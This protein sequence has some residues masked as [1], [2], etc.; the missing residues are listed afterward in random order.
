MR[1]T[2]DIALWRLLLGALACLL[3]VGPSRGFAQRGYPRIET[4][5]PGA[6]TR[7]TTTEVLLQGRYNLKEA[8]RIVF[9]GEGVS[10]SVVDWSE[11]EIT[12]PA[13][14]K[15]PEFPTETLR[16]KVTVAEDA[17]PGIRPFRILT[18]GS[19]SALAHLFVTEAPSVN[20]S[21]PND[22]AVD[23]QT[24]EIPQTVNGLLD[25]EVDFDV[26]KFDAEA[27]ERVSFIVH[28]A[29]L[30]H[31]V[32]HLERNFADLI[33]SLRDSDDNEF[34]VADDWNGQDP[35]LFHTFEQSGT[36]YLQ[37]REARY[38]SGKDKWWYAL[39]VRTTPHVTSIFP[40][41]AKAGSRAKLE[42]KGFNL[43]G[44]GPYEVDVPA[45]ADKEFRFQ[46]ATAQGKSDPVS[47]LM[48][49]LLTATEPAGQRE[50][51]EISIPAGISGRISSE[52]E[53]DRYRFT[54]RKGDALEFDVR[55]G[56]AFLDPLLEIR[57][58]SGTLLA[59][60]DDGVNTL[61]QG[62]RGELAFPADKN[63]RIEWIAPADGQYE[64]QVRDANYFGGADY[65]YHL[66][67]RPQVPDFALIVDDD[68]MP[69]GPGESYTSVVTIERRNGFDGPVELF[70]RGLPAGVLFEKSVIPSHLKQGNVVLTGALDA[71]PDARNVEVYGVASVR[72]AGGR[73]KTIERTAMPF[74]PMGQAGGRSFY[75]VPSLMAAAV[76][77]SD[78]IMEATP[79]EITLRPGESATVDIKVTRNNFDGPIEMNV[80]LW[81]L[82]QSLSALPAGI[83]F[84]EKK[85]KTSLGPGET[86]GR[87]TFR[88]E[89]DA[90]PLDDYL[91]TVLGQ[92]TYNRVFMTRVAA[93][94]RLTIKP[95]A[96]RLSEAE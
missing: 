58:A 61:G 95:D 55:R 87:V 26:Y 8:S 62:A 96:Q 37:L 76:E 47:L 70:A 69:V 75:P 53:T 85:S 5:Y 73:T 33:L 93:F 43:E 10:A 57:D 6:V 48:T 3:L 39:S 81:N 14:N 22:S 15:L 27:G 49:D 67:V 65:V 78:L 77:G 41:V 23:A 32:P 56:N 9:D 42:F 54:A 29:R 11:R 83:I 50:F 71:K 51:T 82:T 38:H 20:E 34:V 28:A 66:I 12:E 74:A 88:A 35:Q 45:D 44:L 4:I 30:Q 84:E 59:A 60:Y 31:P 16:I 80:I 63:A 1:R 40:P 18:K 13:K 36:Y 89:A 2:A 7:G 94:F 52:G 64:A 90:P 17:M 24:I 21:E 72:L 91:M 86:E 68:R 46:V 19:L 92:I 79:R 25:K